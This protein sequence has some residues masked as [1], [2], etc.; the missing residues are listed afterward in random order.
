MMFASPLRPSCSQFQLSDVYELREVVGSGSYGN[1]L[2]ARH[3]LTGE[4]VAIKIIPKCILQEAPSLHHFESEVKTLSPI[5]HPLIGR[6]FDVFEE[7]D[8]YSIVSEYSTCDL[9]TYVNRTR[10][11]VERECK[12]LFAQ[13]VCAVGFLHDECHIV[14]RDLK[15]ENVLLDRNRNI[16]LIDFG[17]AKS[18]VDGGDVFSS[19]CGSPAYVAPEVVTG[20][21]YTT[22]VDVWSLGVMLYAMA[23]GELPF[24]AIDSDV[25]LQQIAWGQPH[26]PCFLSDNLTSLLVAM[27]EKDAGRRITLA[28]IRVHPWLEHTGKWTA[29]TGV[30]TEIINTLRG[31]GVEISEHDVKHDVKSPGVVCYKILERKKIVDCWV[32]ESASTVQT[33]DR[34]PIV[35]APPIKPRKRPYV[36]SL[37]TP[38]KQR[39][40]ENEAA[41]GNA[42]IISPL[43]GRQT[44]AAVSPIRLQALIRSP[45]RVIRK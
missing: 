1:I 39:A 19:R 6:I 32:P 18:F 24:N 25:M 43:T 27:L 3:R 10:G 40:D 41:H 31:R 7:S 29:V 22:A 45:K 20:Q 37:W 34:A 36:A 15:L 35:H 28:Q 8:S 9:L 30:D 26:F 4:D 17:F 33:P 23:T 12:T 38:T 16:R 13:L 5:N 44:C 42:T 11:V 2:K 14:H 21:P